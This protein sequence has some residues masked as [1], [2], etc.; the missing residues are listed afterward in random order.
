MT[1]PP[2][3]IEEEFIPEAGKGGGTRANKVQKCTRKQTV[4][5]TV[6]WNRA[7]ED[8]FTRGLIGIIELKA[9]LAKYS[10]LFQVSNI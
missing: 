4:T 3:Q 9:F 7:Q 8:E 10:L 1:P 6:L 2:L 5:A